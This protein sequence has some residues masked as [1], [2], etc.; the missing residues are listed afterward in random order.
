MPPPDLGFDVVREDDRGARELPRKVH[1]W[2]EEVADDQ[3]EGLLLE[4]R[5]N[6]SGV[7]ARAILRDRIRQRIRHARGRLQIEA[8]RPLRH[9][10]ARDRDDRRCHATHTRDVGRVALGIRKGEVRDLMPPGEV[11]HQ[12]PRPQLSAFIQR[13]QQVRLQPENAHWGNEPWA[14]KAFGCRLCR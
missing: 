11:A 6:R 9:I 13:Q 1:G 2:N 5:A 4:T 12:V 3:V 7:R 8:E 14:R 10:G